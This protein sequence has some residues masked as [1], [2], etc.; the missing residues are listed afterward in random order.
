LSGELVPL[1]RSLANSGLGGPRLRAFGQHALKMH[2]SHTRA[3]S[4]LAFEA[5]KTIACRKRTWMLVFYLRPSVLIYGSFFSHCGLAHILHSANA[6]RHF[7]NAATEMRINNA[8]E[9]EII[10]PVLNIPSS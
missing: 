10:A 4:S 8:S 3:F 6:R 1:F 7:G 9:P 5:A 2:P